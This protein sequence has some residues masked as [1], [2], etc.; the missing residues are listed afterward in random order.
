[1]TK[2]LIHGRNNC[3][4]TFPC[5]Q[6]LLPQFSQGCRHVLPGNITWRRHH[7]KSRLSDMSDIDGLGIIL[8]TYHTVAADWKWQASSKA[9]LLFSTRWRRVVLDEGKLPDSAS[10]IQPS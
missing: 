10:I 5:G 6:S 1:M 9:S 2:C 8:T 3:Q 4:S 7:G